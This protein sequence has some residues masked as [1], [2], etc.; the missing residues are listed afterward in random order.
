MIFQIIFR[1]GPRGWSFPGKENDGF[2]NFLGHAPQNSQGYFFNG[3]GVVWII[4]GGLG[5]LGYI[6]FR[7][8]KTQLKMT[9]GAMGGQGPTAAAMDPHGFGA[10][11]GANKRG[12]T[13]KPGQVWQSATGGDA[14]AP[15]KWFRNVRRCSAGFRPIVQPACQWQQVRQ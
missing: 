4:L 8:S 15:E 5:P 11:I 9:L 6:L 12:L 7:F 2:L 14:K 13:C 10:P 1:G 3:G